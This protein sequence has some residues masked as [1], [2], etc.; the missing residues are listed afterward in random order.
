MLDSYEDFKKKFYSFIGIDLNSYKEAQM[1]RRIDGFASKRGV[2]GYVEFYNLLR[3]DS[4]VCNQFIT[5]LT[6]NVS[7]FY[8]NPAQWQTLRTDIIKHIRGF[9]K[10]RIKVWSAACSTGDEPYTLAMVLSEFYPLSNI[11]IIA[12]D[13]DRE[14]LAIAKKGI[15]MERSLKGLP[16]DLFDKY[17]T[18]QDDGYHVDESLK[19]CIKFQKHDLLKDRYPTDLDLIVCR[20]VLIYFTDEAKDN[21]FNNF[22][23]SLKRDGVL[24]VGS[25]EQIINYQ[26]YGLDSF[27]SFF[28]RKL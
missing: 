28:Y 26:K 14:V 3:S 21:I 19:K 22:C 10:N 13:L 18:K 27:K 11:E 1:K 9:A 7:E 5:Y 4:D 25:T 12:T 8:R 24:F 15:Y 23:N 20:N 6:I 17:V 2:K 16:K